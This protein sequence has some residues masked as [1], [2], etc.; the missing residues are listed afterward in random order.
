LAPSWPDEFVFKPATVSK[1]HK[2]VLTVEHDVTLGLD[3]KMGFVEVALAAMDQSGGLVESWYSLEKAPGMKHQVQCVYTQCTPH[4]VVRTARARYC[5]CTHTLIHSPSY[6]LYACCSRPGESTSPTSSLGQP[7]PRRVGVRPRR[8]HREEPLPPR[9]LALA[10]ELELGRGLGLAAVR[11]P[12]LA[13]RRNH[14]GAP[15]CPGLLCFSSLG[16][17]AL[18][19]GMVDA[20]DS[21]VYRVHVLCQGCVGSPCPERAQGHGPLWCRAARHRE[22]PLHQVGCVHRSRMRNVTH[23]ALPS[24]TRL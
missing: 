21:R 2:L 8:Q 23:P 18:H 22:T 16:A 7:S 12:A 19:G 24:A 4:L 10:L 5:V 1:S 14:Q 11:L 15:R 9:P 6:G 20:T 17:W 3:K 13:R